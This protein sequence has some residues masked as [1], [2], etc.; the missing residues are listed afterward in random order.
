MDNITLGRIK[1]FSGLFILIY[2][3]INLYYM[4]KTGII[5]SSFTMIGERFTPLLIGIIFILDGMKDGE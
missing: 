2:S 5:F 4:I 1:F 3:L